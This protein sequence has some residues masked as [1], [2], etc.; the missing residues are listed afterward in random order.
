[1]FDKG[2]CTA[3]PGRL[4]RA[5]DSFPSGHTSST[6]TIAVFM[7]LYLNAKLK[8]FSNVQPRTWKV[9]LLFLPIFGA[10][11]VG[12]TLYL[13][14][15]HHWYDVVAGA[16]L[17]AFVALLAYRTMYASIWNFQINHIPL[18]RDEQFVPSNNYSPY[19]TFFDTT[20]T[21]R[22]GWGT[23]G[24]FYLG[25]G[26]PP[27]DLERGILISPLDQTPDQ[28]LRRRS[29][30]KPRK[31]STSTGPTNTFG[32]P[33][34][35]NPEVPEIREERPSRLQT[36]GTDDSGKPFPFTEDV[37]RSMAE[38]GRKDYAAQL[39]AHRNQRIKHDSVLIGP[40]NPTPEQP[41]RPAG[42]WA[43]N[44]S[45][46]QHDDSSAGSSGTKKLTT[47]SKPILKLNTNSNGS[48]GEPEPPKPFIR[49]DRKDN[50]FC[51]EHKASMDSR[52]SYKVRNYR[53][54]DQAIRDQDTE[55]S[56]SH[57]PEDEILPSDEIPP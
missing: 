13:D 26:H 23:F 10:A 50:P 35:P 15:F 55:Y 45:K 8:V 44:G 52:R 56:L 38:V 18:V 30:A 12:A 11:A 34:E 7:F 53:L 49:I 2:V 14:Y 27:G 20:L 17:G 9:L 24:N 3:V 4:V 42:E 39:K 29:T 25:T 54:D 37:L 5:M 6:F 43:D 19:E 33:E 40:S 16:L 28:D 1:M 51:A 36:D 46:P 48:S 57:Y 32:Q 21:K 47:S 22:A 31:S 41:S